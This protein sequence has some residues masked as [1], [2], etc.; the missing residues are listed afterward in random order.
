[1]RISSLLSIFR[2]RQAR[3]CIRVFRGCPSSSYLNMSTDTSTNN[4]M[5][6]I[7]GQTNGGSRLSRV[8]TLQR[9]ENLMGTPLSLANEEKSD[10]CGS[11][12]G[13]SNANMS[14]MREALHH[15]VS[16]SDARIAQEF[17]SKHLLE[18]EHLLKGKVLTLAIQ[19][20]GSS[21]SSLDLLIKVMKKACEHDST[22][23][24]DIHITAFLKAA[25]SEL[26]DVAVPGRFEEVL[27]HVKSILQ[28]HKE[29]LRS[30]IALNAYVSF[31]ASVVKRRN[32]KATAEDALVEISSSLKT[33]E[34]W[35][36]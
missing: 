1:M 10:D 2:T 23:I 26:K 32:G 9:I 20:L 11:S 22:S 21:R 33:D 16:L 13:N 30:Q 28:Q 14:K 31:F 18:S 3:D 34:E 12:S 15:V 8:R 24:T 19:A 27:G 5:R 4:H 17:I 6:S 36:K 29:L 25:K 35:T 7:R